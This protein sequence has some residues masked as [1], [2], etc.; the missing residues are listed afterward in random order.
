MQSSVTKL[1]HNKSKNEEFLYLVWMLKKSEWKHAENNRIILTLQVSECF[2]KCFFKKLFSS[3]LV[4][5][6][7]W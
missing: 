5:G 7:S 4:A 1:Q 3:P 6:L 2:K